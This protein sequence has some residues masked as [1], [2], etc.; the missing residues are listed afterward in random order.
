MQKNL[1]IIW[2]TVFRSKLKLLLIYAP[3]DDEKGIKNGEREALKILSNILNPAFAPFFIK[4]SLSLKL[5]D[6]NNNIRNSGMYENELIDPDSYYK[7][8]H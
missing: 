1:T 7:M 8:L 4:W 5:S 2:L 3:V 6:I